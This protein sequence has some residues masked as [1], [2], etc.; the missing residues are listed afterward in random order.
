M[1]LIGKNILIFTHQEREVQ[2]TVSWYFTKGIKHSVVFKH[3]FFVTLNLKL[4]K[5]PNCGE[6]G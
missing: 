5:F 3:I 4:L 2:E 1:P 6:R